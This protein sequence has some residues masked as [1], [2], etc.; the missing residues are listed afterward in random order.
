MVPVYPDIS[1]HDRLVFCSLGFP[2]TEYTSI[3]YSVPGLSSSSSFVV[4]DPCCRGTSVCFIMGSV[5][6]LVVL[7]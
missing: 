3:L 7:I 4:F 6:V 1:T 2:T 5:L